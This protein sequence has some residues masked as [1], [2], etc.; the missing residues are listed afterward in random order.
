[1]NYFVA[2]ID[3]DSGKTLVSAILCEALGFDYWKPVQAGFPTDSDA[4]KAWL[5]NT[6]IHQE[7][8]VLKTPA[9]PH[10]AAKIDGITIDLKKITLPKSMNGLIIEGAG[11]C[12]VPLNDS[13]FVI[14]LVP[15]LNAEI[16]LV[17]DLYLGSINHT[18]LTVNLLQ[19][20]KYQV[21][22]IIFNGE[23]NPESERIILKHSGYRCLLR[24]AKEPTIT[25]EAIR[26]Y[27]TIL[28]TN[29]K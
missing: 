10:A 23:A 26:R 9:S 29:W 16:V 3:T 27:A 21:K 17:A 24:I 4:I 19:S 12:L 8:Y 2:G 20:R 25:L 1:M 11:G 7:A 5:P 6:I 18:L 28:K 13:D 15:V 22:G 14:D